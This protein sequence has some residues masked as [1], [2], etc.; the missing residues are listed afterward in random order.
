MLWNTEKR[1]WNVKEELLSLLAI[2]SYVSARDPPYLGGLCADILHGE[3]FLFG[4]DIGEKRRV[5]AD[6]RHF[7]ATE[8]FPNEIRVLGLHCLTVVNV[9]VRKREREAPFNRE[10]G[11]VLWPEWINLALDWSGSPYANCSHP[12]GVGCEE[13]L[14]TVQ[15]LHAVG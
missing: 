3:W 2:F 1:K 7:V 10:R 15:E 13:S 6:S 9:V 11:R 8:A 5:L 14:T 4:G 12:L